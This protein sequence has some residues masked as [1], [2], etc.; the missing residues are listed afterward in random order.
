MNK[1]RFGLG[2]VLV[3]IG[4]SISTMSSWTRWHYILA[5]TALVIIICGLIV[6]IMEYVKKK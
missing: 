3:I 6:M 2:L 1:K 4:S 5:I